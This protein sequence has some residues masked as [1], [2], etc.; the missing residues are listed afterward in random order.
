MFCF[1]VDKSSS[2][3]GK[4][5]NCPVCGKVFSSP[6]KVEVHMV[7]HTKQKNFKETI[8]P[9]YKHITNHRESCGKCCLSS[10]NHRTD[11]SKNLE[12]DGQGE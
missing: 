10:N 1:Q 5:Y 11:G 2:G 3:R 6:S 7:T 4:R 12:T 8:L 9:S